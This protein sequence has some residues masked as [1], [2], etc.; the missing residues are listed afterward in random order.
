M[1]DP[2]SEKPILF[3]VIAE[4]NNYDQFLV[5]TGLPFAR[6]I[7]DI[8][9]PYENKKPFFIDGMAQRDRLS[10]CGGG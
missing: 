1:A 8:V 2:P 9:I 7:E 5:M 3:A 6:V 4:A 10:Q